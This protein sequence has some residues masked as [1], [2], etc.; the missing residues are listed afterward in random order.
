[1]K[2]Y[3]Y[4][5]S[6]LLIEKGG[7][8][9][10]FDPGSYSFNEGLIKPD[11][12]NS[13]S[14]I[15]ITHNHPDHL[16][17]TALKTILKTNNIPV[18]GNAET[19][20]CLSNYNINGTL[21]DGGKKQVGSFSI[22]AIPAQHGKI[23]APTPLNTAYIIDNA[24]LNPGDSFAASLSRVRVAVLALPITA[25]WM[26]EIESYKFAKKIKPKV[27]IPIHDGFL[28][29]YYLESKYNQYKKLYSSVNILFQPLNLKTAYEI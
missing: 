19:L 7:K 27:I 9:I 8:K 25:S 3:K 12:F 2:I 11:N 17:V 18:F 29:N 21:F 26:T 14:A 6:C 16:D 5:H 10:L 28:K 23:L 1:M 4:I 15:F 24:L 13:L 20:D 22:K